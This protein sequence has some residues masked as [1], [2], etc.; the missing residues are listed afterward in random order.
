MPREGRA[1]SAGVER[2]PGSEGDRRDAPVGM[3]NTAVVDG[4]AP[5]EHREGGREIGEGDDA[6][7]VRAGSDPAHDAGRDDQGR[8]VGHADH[9]NERARDA[10]A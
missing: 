1:H 6:E 5:G 8:D 7:R 2:E 4:E 3:V 10:G 9:Q